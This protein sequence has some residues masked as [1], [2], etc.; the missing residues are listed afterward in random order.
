MRS[1][2]LLSREYQFYLPDL[3][4]SVL[5]QTIDEDNV[6]IR[7]ARSNFPEQRKRAFIR[8]LSAEGFI[9][10]RFQHFDGRVTDCPGLTWV[11]DFSHLRLDPRWA[12]QSR[13]FVVR[14]FLVVG[15]IWLTA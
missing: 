11:I 8:R 14:L 5:V 4:N 7:A 12:V 3:D 13:R 6:I 9:P 15:L 1:E 10:D 2:K